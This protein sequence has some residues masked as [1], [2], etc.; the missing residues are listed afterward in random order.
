ML[1]WFYNSTHDGRYTVHSQ[2]GDS[3]VCT[4]THMT[5]L[6]S[7]TE[8]TGVYSNIDVM[9]AVCTAVYTVGLYRNTYMITEITAIHR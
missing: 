3:K 4:W 9:T 8:D 2:T 1:V 6:Y 5:G 7:D